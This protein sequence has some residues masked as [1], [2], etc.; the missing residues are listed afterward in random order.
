MGPAVTAAKS[1]G[2]DV[3]KHIKLAPPFQVTKLDKYFVHFKKIATSLE[4]PKEVW[5][6]L[7]QSVLIGKAREIHA[8]L[9]VEKSAQYE[10]R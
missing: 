3:S 2:F 8:A 9:P 7:S 6:F 10:V 1:P 5:T 4:C